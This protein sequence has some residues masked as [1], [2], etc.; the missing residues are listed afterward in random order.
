[1]RRSDSTIASA[2]RASATPISWRRTRPGLAIGPSRLNTVGMPISRRAGAAKRNA[3]WNARR[4][5]E[6]DAGLLDAARDP[7][8]RQLD[9]DAELLEHVGRAALRRRRPGAVLAHRDAGAGDHDRRHRRHVD[10]V[11]S[12]RRRCRRCRRP[13]ARSSSSSGTSSAAAS[14][15]SSRPD[16]SSDV[17][18]LAR[19][20]TTNPISCADVAWPARIVSIAAD[21]SSPVRS[22]PAIRSPMSA[23]QVRAGMGVD[24][25]H[26]R[27]HRRRA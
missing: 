6:A 19:R 4:E 3:G 13:R 14:T 25:A 9:D 10:R 22:R 17:S 20:A 26:R 24:A 27:V 11:S 1:M 16:S 7:L 18:P 23:G 2:K 21:A 15:A 12:G 5:A 8:G